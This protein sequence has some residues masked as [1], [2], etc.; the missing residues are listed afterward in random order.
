MN[1]FFL[2]CNKKRK[3]TQS[4]KV[5]INYLLSQISRFYRFSLV[6]L[7]Y[8]IFSVIPSIR[9]FFGHT[10]FMSKNHMVSIRSTQAIILVWLFLIVLD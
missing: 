2:D 7:I 1:I 10:K 4:L 5:D 6:E 9:P 8:K 3:I